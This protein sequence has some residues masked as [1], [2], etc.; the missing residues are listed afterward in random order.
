MIPSFLTEISFL[1][2]GTEILLI[3]LKKEAEA[4]GIASVATE[5]FVQISKVFFHDVE[6]KLGPIFTGDFLRTFRKINNTTFLR[7]Y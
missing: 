3:V 1:V 5:L 7:R 6:M 2:L 4:G